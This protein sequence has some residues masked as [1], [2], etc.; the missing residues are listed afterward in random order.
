MRDELKVGLS[1]VPI[2]IMSLIGM[3][4]G[5]FISNMYNW[6]IGFP[7][8]VVIGFVLVLPFLYLHSAMYR[9]YCC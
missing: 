6:E 8:G 3:L 4:Y 5:M 7:L 1:L 9:K 2:P